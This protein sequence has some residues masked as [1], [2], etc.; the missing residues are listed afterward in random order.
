MKIFDCFMYFDEDLI[1]DIR[2]NTLDKFV[3]YFVIVESTST[4]SGE[5]NE[6]KFDIKKYKDFKD[7]IIYLIY[8]NIPKEIVN[9]DT[10][11]NE[12]HKEYNKIM[13]A[14]YRENSHRN[15]ISEGLKNASNEDI[16][17]ISDIDEI[18]NLENIDFFKINK[19]LILF[20]QNM[21]YYKFNLKAPNILWT[22]TKACKK[23]Y[24][25]SPQW[26]RNV[27]DRKYPFYRLDT[28]FSDLKYIDV[29][30]IQN[31]GWH[32]TNIKKASEIEHKLKS[33]LHHREFE[34]NPL[35]AEQIEKII[36]NKKAIYN[37]NVDKRLSKIGDGVDLEKI[38]NKN[39]PNYIKENIVK[40][41]EWLD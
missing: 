7:K 33:Y 17:M 12:K 10:I 22:G 26:L 14:V 29:E 3:D 6:L 34:L 20:K 30:I 13:N 24:L 39:L 23:K 21:F 9:I 28:L 25:K 38:E 35:S 18:P 32:F 4:H 2:L 1:L 31:G 15:Y 16:I 37:L 19:K 11:I 40:Y 36:N 8:E 41:K 27:R 5:K